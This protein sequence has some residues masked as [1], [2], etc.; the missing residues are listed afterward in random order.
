MT[1]CPPRGAEPFTEKLAA[2]DLR[3]LRRRGLDATTLAL[4]EESQSVRDRFDPATGEVVVTCFTVEAPLR[5]EPTLNEEHD[6]YRWCDVDQAEALLYW[7]EPREL[8]RAL[9]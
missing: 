8:L 2:R 4:A 3:R 9:A 6:D 7:P 1:C 5:W